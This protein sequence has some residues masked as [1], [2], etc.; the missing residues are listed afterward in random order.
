MHFFFFFT[1]LLVG[2]YK[3][4]YKVG[5]LEAENPEFELTKLLEGGRV[6]FSIIYHQPLC[7]QHFTKKGRT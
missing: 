6:Y 7:L 5:I 3:H 1:F 4:T 2:I